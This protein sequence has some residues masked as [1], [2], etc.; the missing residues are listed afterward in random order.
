MKKVRC[1]TQNEQ[2]TLENAE[3]K[4]SSARVRRRAQII[5]L[6]NKGYELKEIADICRITRQ[7]ASVTIN[8]W[9]DSGLSGLYD[10][11][12]PGQ[13]PVLTDEDIQFIHDMAESEPH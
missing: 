3:K 12:R 7:T 13:P 8:R 5:L 11:P 1:L 4:H 2:N 10:A 6:S 9:E